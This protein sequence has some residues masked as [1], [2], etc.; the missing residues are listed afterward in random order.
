MQASGTIACLG[1]GA[2]SGLPY[3]IECLVSM[4]RCILIPLS[5]LFALFY[6][7]GRASWLDDT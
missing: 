2:I 4:S 7:M 1:K 3:S 5:C 6:N